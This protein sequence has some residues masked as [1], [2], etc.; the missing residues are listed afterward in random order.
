ML[1]KK[2]WII[3]SFLLVLLI[4]QFAIAQGPTFPLGNESTPK[5]VLFHSITCPHCQAERKWLETIR[6][7]YPDLVIEEYEA[8][9]NQALFEQYAKEYNT[10]TSGV[11]RTFVSNKVFAGFSEGE[12]DL[13]YNE[14]YKGY[15]G[16][17]SQIENAIQECFEKCGLTSFDR[18]I[19]KS[20][21]DVLVKDLLARSPNSTSSSAWLNGTY[22]IAWWSQERIASNLDY[23]NVVVYVNA[24]T[25]S[26]IRSDAP[27]GKIAGLP[28]PDSRFDIFSV[29]YLVIT[30]TLDV[31][32]LS[33]IGLYLVLYLFFE[34]RLKI[35][36]R[37]WTAG[38]ITLIII[39][40]YVIFTSMPTGVVQKF[41]KGFPFPVF[42]FII[43]LADGFNPCAFTVLA[44]LLSL[45][46]HT[47]SRKKMLLI[48]VV[49]IL[50]SAFMYFIFIMAINFF[51]SWMFSQYGKLLFMVLGLLVLAAGLINLK[52]Y[53]FFKKGISLTMPEGQRDKIFKSAGKIVKKVDKAEGKKA[54]FAA[55]LGTVVLATLVNIVELGCTAMFPMAY[56]SALIS[57][58]GKDL[59]FYHFAYTLFYSFVY[60]IPLFAILG[61]F[62]Y[63][64]KSDRINEGQA[65]LLKLV[66]G[67]M[68]IGL[69][70]MLLLKPDLLTLMR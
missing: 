42:V 44:V 40:G 61:N 24:S 59:G 48:G 9:D 41:A 32:F 34:K 26:I 12:G 50:T 4:S 55:L 13:S 60:V 62:L 38:F 45:L 46:T 7:K 16:Y 10:S 1:N 11:P 63:T 3:F 56:T 67:L 36:S 2:T 52:D 20:K 27:T 54:L 57:N 39:A 5:L 6:I 65:R 21:T 17:S 33:L 31:F 30:N 14:G 53:F 66:G 58:Y 37:Y 19:E 15:I 23:P 29:I 51:G 8:N 49:F 28:K 25:N 22:A 68:M 70:A 64:F 18:A 35:D 47:N 69:G 43:A